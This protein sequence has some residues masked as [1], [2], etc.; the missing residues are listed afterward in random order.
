MNLYL[1]SKIRRMTQ[2]TIMGSRYRLIED[3]PLTAI[4]I[5]PPNNETAKP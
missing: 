4:L 1:K 2:R 3:R 5:S